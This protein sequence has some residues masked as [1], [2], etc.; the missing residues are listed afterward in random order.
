MLVSFLLFESINSQ[1]ERGLSSEPLSDVEPE[2]EKILALGKVIEDRRQKRDLP[3]IKISHEAGPEQEPLVSRVRQ[4]MI[5]RCQL[6]YGVLAGA[7]KER[8]ADYVLAIAFDDP[9]CEDPDTENL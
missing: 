5:C 1:L 9:V 2:D 6:E 7:Q 3:N 8:Y 4:T